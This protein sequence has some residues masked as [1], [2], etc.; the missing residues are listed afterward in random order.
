MKYA[1]IY[2]KIKFIF[3]FGEM[4][5]IYVP[6]CYKSDAMK[7]NKIYPIISPPTLIMYNT[8]LPLSPFSS[9]NIII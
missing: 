9:L 6:V 5:L 2:N 1:N 8:H 7:K 3:K 4:K